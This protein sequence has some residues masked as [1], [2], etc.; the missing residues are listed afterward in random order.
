MLSVGLRRKQGGLVEGPNASVNTKELQVAA[1]HHAGSAAFTFIRRRVGARPP[2]KA[3]RCPRRTSPSSAHRQENA[4]GAPSV[5][6]TASMK[7]EDLQE[8]RVARGRA[9]PFARSSPSPFFSIISELGY[10]RYTRQ[11]E[12]GAPAAKQPSFCCHSLQFFG[13][14]D[15]L[16]GRASPSCHR[17]GRIDRSIQIMI[18]HSC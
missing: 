14:L 12:R 11:E 15:L 6:P 5:L 16:M 17:R 10:Q 13:G 4:R 3:R 18:M 9:L 7:Q 1:R 2:E 8:A